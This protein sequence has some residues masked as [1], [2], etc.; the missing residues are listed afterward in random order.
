MVHASD[1][2]NLAQFNHSFAINYII[3]GLFLVLHKYLI[4]VQLYILF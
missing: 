1:F 3:K 4:F 2:L